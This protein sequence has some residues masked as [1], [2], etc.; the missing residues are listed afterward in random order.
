MKSN[1]VCA[2]F[3]TLATILDN[4]LLN[5]S[6]RYDDH[7]TRDQISNFFAESCNM[8]LHSFGQ[9]FSGKKKYDKHIENEAKLYRQCRD[10]GL[11]ND[12]E[13]IVDSGGFQASIGKLKK[14][15]TQ[16]LID[17]YHQFLV[18]EKDVYDRA[19][20]LDLPPGP[21]C[22]LF[23]SFDQ[24]YDKNLETYSMAANLPQDVKDKMIYIHHFRTPKL[25]DIYTKIMREND[26]FKEFKHHGT[27]GIVANMASDTQ[28]PCIIYVIPMIPLINEALKHG[29]DTLHFHILGGANFRDILFY[30][31]FRLHLLKKHAIEVEISY[32]SSGLFKGLMVGRYISV[33]DDGVIR[34]LD[35]RTKKLNL[36]FLNGEKR[37]DRYKR[38]LYELSERYGFKDIRN[39][40][41][42]NPDTGTFYDEM[43]V[44]SMLHMLNQFAD[45]QTM[46]REKAESIYPL[47]EDGLIEEFIREVEMITRNLNGGKISRKQ[48]A[49]S[50]SIVKSLDML[51][52]LD[53]TF[54]K[55]IVDKVLS[56]DEF[57]DL[58]EKK[59]LTF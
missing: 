34:K 20:V 6:N 30:E 15:E 29:R 25:W 24:I 10:T 1:Y 44:Y 39:I 33:L 27:G 19:F 43:R 51:T 12:S 11:F 45:I 56:K 50:V 23:E 2:G 32:D 17:L 42:Y 5:K 37:I 38:A 26:M 18:Q 9:N 13:F 16:A 35:L 41:I 58:E 49:K 4:F 59:I 31:L 53:E 8:F 7:F 47:Y 54:C 22:E 28:I 52:S 55:Y 48:R 40:D 3:E 57:T 46:A 36:R 14:D 21:G